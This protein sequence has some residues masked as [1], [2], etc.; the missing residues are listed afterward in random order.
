MPMSKC[1][2]LKDTLESWFYDIK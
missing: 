1:L 2:E